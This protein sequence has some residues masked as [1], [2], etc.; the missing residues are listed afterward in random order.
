MPTGGAVGYVL[1]HFYRSSLPHKEANGKISRAE[2][3]QLTIR[4]NLVVP[5]DEFINSAEAKELLTDIDPALLKGFTVDGKLYLLPEEWNNMVIY[6]NTKV[7]KE[8]GITPPPDNWTWDDFLTLAKRLTSGEGPD[9]RFG[10][11]IPFF[12]FGLSPFWYSNETA[13]LKED[14]KESNLSDPKFLESVQF[15]HGFAGPG[16]QRSER[17]ISTLCD[18]DTLSHILDFAAA[19]LHF[20]IYWRVALPLAKPALA[21]LTIL[22][23]TYSWNSYFLPLIFFSSW[24]KMTLPLGMFALSNVYGAGN[25]SVIMA[26][27]TLAIGPVLLLFLTAQRHIISGMVGSALKG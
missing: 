15:I 14:L 2:G 20:T 23:F 9:K 17:S 22:T 25:V 12:F 18:Q 7:F 1:P 11:G 10:F 5:L 3:V 8:A 24:D 27:V 21:T 6:Y 19:N 16:K 4:R 26:A 13:V